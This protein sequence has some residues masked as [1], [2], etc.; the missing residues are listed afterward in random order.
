MF[1]A[2]PHITGQRLHSGSVQFVRH[3]VAH[4][5][6]LSGGEYE[7]Q[8]P[9]STSWIF[10]YTLW[11]FSQ[12]GALKNKL[13]DFLPQH[14]LSQCSAFLSTLQALLDFLAKTRERQRDNLVGASVCASSLHALQPEEKSVL[15]QVCD[16]IQI[17]HCLGDVVAVGPGIRRKRYPERSHQVDY[18]KDCRDQNSEAEEHSSSQSKGSSRRQSVTSNRRIPVHRCC[19]LSSVP[20]T[21]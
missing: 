7:S 19:L 9:G 5:S 10:R 11:V 4:L 18:E 3:V 2:D 16:E 21:T 1:K 8:F 12:A 13:I 14:L 20:Q 6:L 15:F 17:P